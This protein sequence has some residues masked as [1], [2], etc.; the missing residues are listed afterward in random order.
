MPGAAVRFIHKCRQFAVL[1]LELE[2]GYRW[3]GKLAA[4][5]I[6]GSPVSVRLDGRTF[7][8]L[9]APR[10]VAAVQSDDSLVALENL[11]TA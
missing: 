7:P 3:T 6:D 9:A 2:H 11:P 4:S 5:A 8:D 10:A 1:D